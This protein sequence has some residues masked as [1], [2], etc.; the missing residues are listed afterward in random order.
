[1]KGQSKAPII[2]FENLS[3]KRNKLF[4]I[5]DKIVVVGGCFDILHL[6]H[7]TLI[8]NA[9]KLGDRLV[10]VIESDKFILETKKREPFHNQKQR[11]IVMASIRDVDLV[12]KFP[13]IPK[14][15]R[16]KSYRSLVKILKPGFIAVSENDKMINEK[17]EHAKI[18][19][20]EVK[21]VTKILPSLSSSKII[22]Y[23][24]LLS[25]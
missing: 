8:E 15:K 5:N 14:S 12:I 7:V 16:T 1:M 13:F 3:Q 23:G 10:V 4:D 11:A 9:K 17:I 22:Q 6:G 21:I 2:D 18:V 19:G 20:A 24:S 25:D